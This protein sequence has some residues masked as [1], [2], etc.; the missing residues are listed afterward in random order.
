MTVAEY[1]DV[2][3][4][5]LLQNSTSPRCKR[6]AL[7]QLK[8][9]SAMRNELKEIAREII[10]SNLF[11]RDVANVIALYCASTP[12]VSLQAH[13]MNALVQN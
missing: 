12:I 4:M 9:L 5:I 10:S 2:C 8:C 11:P 13:Q 7:D 6:I 3:D 1:E